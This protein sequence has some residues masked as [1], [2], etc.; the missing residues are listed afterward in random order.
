[1][2]SRNSTTKNLY[3]MR[4]TPEFTPDTKPAVFISYKR[5]PDRNTAVKCAVYIQKYS[6]TLLLA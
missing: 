2:Q 5:D 3:E 4:G 1:M 6:R